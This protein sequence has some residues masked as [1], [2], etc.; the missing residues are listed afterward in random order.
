MKSIGIIFMQVFLCNFFI[1]STW[2]QDI[3]GMWKA[4][5]DKSGYARA[6]VNI[7]QNNDGSYEGKIEEVYPLPGH[8][9][10]F[11]DKCFRCK[12]ELKDTPLKGMKILYGFKK[13]MNKADEYNDG[14]IIDPMS[15]N[16]YKGRIK[17]NASVTR[18][19]LRGYIG[20]SALGRTQVWMRMD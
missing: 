12:G 2:A 10:A 14:H 4:I 16:V 11:T 3:T 5:D 19:N 1:A 17:T 9:T 7:Y 6:K 8:A 20:T 15:G 13:N 18:I